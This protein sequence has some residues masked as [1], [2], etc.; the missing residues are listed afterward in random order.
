[1][2]E[3]DG[4]DINGYHDESAALVEERYASAGSAPFINWSV[5]FDGVPSQHLKLLALICALLAF[6]TV[7]NIA[8][9]KY[10][11][12]H[13]KLLTEGQPNHNAAAFT[14]TNDHTK[15]LEVQQP[16]DTLQRLQQLRASSSETRSRSEDEEELISSRSTTVSHGSLEE[17]LFSSSS[18]ESEASSKLTGEAETDGGD[19]QTRRK[20]DDLISQYKAGKDKI[21]SSSMRKEGKYGKKGAVSKNYRLSSSE[22]Q[23]GSSIEL[24]SIIPN[25]K[26]QIQ[27]N[28]RV[29]ER[30]LPDNEKD[31]DRE[32]QDQM[33]DDAEKEF[34]SVT[35]PTTNN[36]DLE[37]SNSLQQQTAMIQKLQEQLEQQQSMMESL[38]QKKMATG[39]LPQD[40]NSV[41]SRQ[42][43][44]F[45]SVGWAP[46]QQQTVFSQQTA[47]GSLG[48]PQ[49]STPY[50]SQQPKQPYD[51]SHSL[52]QQHQLAGA[53]PLAGTVVGSNSQMHQYQQQPDGTF[54]M[55]PSAAVGSS[56]QMYQY[57]QQP[58]GTFL[59]PPTA[60]VGSSSQM[61]QYQQQPDGTFLMP[62]TGAVASNPQMHQY[63]QQ[64]ETA[65][66]YSNP[67]G[68]TTG[69]A[70][71]SNSD[72]D[73]LNGYKDTW[74]PHEY[75]DT[76]VFWHVPKAG[77]STVK[78]ICGT[79]YLNLIL[80]LLAA[81]MHRSLFI[82]YVL[83]SLLSRLLYAAIE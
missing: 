50:L 46:Q 45:N 82:H 2:T 9:A 67:G 17:D 27:E 78:D 79:W 63:Q 58:D 36:I 16:L 52:Q 74:D 41:Y 68:A 49:D 40:A 76:P 56:S 13:Q 32:T 75:S 26:K 10:S 53:T 64:P 29:S 81:C 20:R 66:Q 14:N 18:A 24:K 39:N 61:Y 6:T 47:S 23:G 7:F 62:S 31:F 42:G 15:L 37:I 73:P 28:E 38:R 69:A 3:E 11:L 30:D 59:M 77:G 1:M 19:E 65:M 4:I 72:P 5:L 51:A 34:I 22:D 33:T 80:S 60:A 55:P 54:L 71:A 83:F 57:Q 35:S 70:A 12:E 44:P 43:A 48:T 8:S 21:N 25:K